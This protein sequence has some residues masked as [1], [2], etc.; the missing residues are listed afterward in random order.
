[1]DAKIIF[2]R[3]LIGSNMDALGIRPKNSRDRCTQ[4]YL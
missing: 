2:D 1:M 3:I 4:P